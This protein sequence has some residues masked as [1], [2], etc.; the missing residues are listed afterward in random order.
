MSKKFVGFSISERAY[1][2]SKLMNIS[3]QKL[4]TYLVDSWLNEH[5]DDY[6]RLFK[7]LHIEEKIQELKQEIVH[8]ESKKQLLGLLEHELAI[9][10]E[11]Y[12]DTKRYVEL[13]HLT[14][15]LSRRIIKYKYNRQEIEE[16]HQDILERI[17]EIQPDF[18]L[19]AQIEMIKKLRSDFVI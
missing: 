19:D 5:E 9:E 12:D 14:K 18:D 16:R 3:I 10:R 11:N 1:E 6:G 17:L 8:L 7:I 4:S 13:H 15:Y 2:R